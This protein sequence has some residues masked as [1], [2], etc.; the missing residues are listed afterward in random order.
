MENATILIV[1]DEDAIVQMVRRVLKKEGFTQILTAN[2]S[3]EALEIVKKETV[4]LILLDVM[5][6]GQT[7]F[8]VSPHIRRFTNAPIFFLT[9]KTSDL[10]KLS[11]FDCGADDYITKPFNPLELIAR[12][13]AHLKRTYQENQG[14]ITVKTSYE[15]ERFTFYP[16]FAEL[17]VDGEIVG[18]SA[19]LLQ[20]LQYF[21]DHPNIV[22]SKDQIYENVWG[23]PSY[24]DSN[25]V[26]VHIRKLREKI[27]KD[28][29]NPDYIVTIRGLGYKFIPIMA[30]KEIRG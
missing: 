26:M 15:Y 16:D 17:V 9:A 5:M 8:E 28:P 19:Q 1:D 22:L 23:V 27:E 2:R 11:G 24:G 6:P 4:D 7:G 13:R 10:D 29:S 18:C 3:E 21:C 30:R 20:L 25:T 12:V 14:A